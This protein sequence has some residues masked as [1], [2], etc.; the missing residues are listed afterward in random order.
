MLT[1]IGT[2]EVWHSFRFSTHTVTCLLQRMA[3]M[4]R[5]RYEPVQFICSFPS[6]QIGTGS[7]GAVYRGVMSDGTEVAIKVIDLPSEAG[8]EDEV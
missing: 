1:M 6:Q 4:K 3:F 2:I 8:F 7:Y 5:I